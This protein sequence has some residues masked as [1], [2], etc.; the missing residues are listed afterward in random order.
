MLKSALEINQTK[1]SNQALRKESKSVV[2]S[3]KSVYADSAPKL[4]LNVGIAEDLAEKDLEEKK[5]VEKDI[6]ADFVDNK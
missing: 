6:T 1:S 2:N 5:D 3:L 4:T